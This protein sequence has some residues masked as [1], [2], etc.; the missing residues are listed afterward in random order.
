MSTDLATLDILQ[1]LD[2]TLTEVQ[3]RAGQIDQ[4]GTA[5]TVLGLTEDLTQVM[6]G[7]GGLKE[8][9]ADLGSLR[10]LAHGRALAAKTTGNHDGQFD[11]AHLAATLSLATGDPENL[12]AARHLMQDAAEAAAQEAELA[13][14]EA[15]ESKQNPAADLSAAIRAITEKVPGVASVTAL[16]AKAGEVATDAGEFAEPT[17]APEP[18]PEPADSADAT[19]SADDMLR[20]YPIE[21]AGDDAWRREMRTLEELADS[22][23]RRAAGRAR[24]LWDI[25]V[26]AEPQAGSVRPMVLNRLIDLHRI[27]RRT[28]EGGITA[29]ERAEFLETMNTLIPGD[30]SATAPIDNRILLNEYRSEDSSSTPTDRLAAAQKLS[31]LHAEKHDSRGMAEA[32]LRAGEEL[33]KLKRM[34]EMYDTYQR[35]LNLAQDAGATDIRIW[36][37]IRLAFAQYLAGD[38]MTATQMLL[39]QDAELPVEK[40]SGSKEKAAMA[41]AK[42]A[43]ANLFGEAGDWDGKNYFLTQAVDLFE[44]IGRPDAAAQ[45]RAQL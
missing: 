1:D 6:A 10:V 38:K 9:G 27:R 11:A 19:E 29:G 21:P 39:D 36:A 2:G 30:L 12:A 17:S 28:V 40:L 23:P 44:A 26:A 34:A 20:V 45:Y 35:S 22:E 13:A 31:N 7:L 3:S 37:T 15:E 41:E 33:E 32:L 24:E 25:V 18:E 4:N 14:A 43:L 8:T 16:N 42:V 5:R